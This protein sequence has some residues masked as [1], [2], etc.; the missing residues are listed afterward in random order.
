MKD[1]PKINIP[2]LVIAGH[3]AVDDPDAL[4][5]FKETEDSLTNDYPDL[6]EDVI[7]MRIGPSDQMLN[8]LMSCAHVALQLSTREGFE[9]KVS[10]ALHLGT[11]LIATRAGGIP[12]QIQ[13]GK[14][15]FLVTPG[16]HD[17]VAKHLYDL[18]TDSELHSTMSEYASK[19]VSDEVSTVGNALSWLYLA[20]E[21]AKGEKLAP[22]GRWINDM[23][24]EKA[25]IPYREGENQLTRNLDLTNN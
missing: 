15:G 2:Q 17:A 19:H 10:E 22:N 13:E 8:A 9:V 21:L 5:I 6:K 23:A 3:G 1:E 7:C 4:K 11:P 24:R 25:G 12:L 20:E 18:F 14:S 16:D